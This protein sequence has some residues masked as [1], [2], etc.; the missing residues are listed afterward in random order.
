MLPAMLLLGLG[1][2]MAYNPLLLSALSSVAPCNSGAASGIVN[3][4]FT[5]GGALGLSVLA[6]I[7]AART[8]DLLVS[9]AGLPFALNSGYQIAFCIGAVFA[10]LAALISGVFLRDGQQPHRDS[11][12]I[13]AEIP[14]II[15]DDAHS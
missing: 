9:G 14:K 4:S 1:T 8:D 6:S 12:N 10:A 3:T 2:G 13:G 7:A 15:F 5:M 11:E